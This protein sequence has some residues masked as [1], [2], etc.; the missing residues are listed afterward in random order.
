MGLQELTTDVARIQL[1]RQNAALLEA[2]LAEER[3]R[4]LALRTAQ[5]VGAPKVSPQAITQPSEEHVNPATVSNKELR[6][7]FAR[8][9]INKPQ[10]NSPLWTPEK[11]EAEAWTP[12]AARRRG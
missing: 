9:Q 3:A 10:K 7:K 2:K 1:T 8:E 4:S 5:A 11:G 12:R 6:E